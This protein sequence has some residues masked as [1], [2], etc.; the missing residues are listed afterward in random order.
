MK[1][2][3]PFHTH[4]W[5]V[6][7][8]PNGRGAP[9]ARPSRA[10]AASRRLGRSIDGVAWSVSTEWA[11]YLLFPLLVAVVLFGRPRAALAAAVGAAVVVGATVTLTMRDGAYHSGPLDAY[12][13][14][15]LEPLLRCLG[16]FVLGLVPFRLAQSPRA[17]A[18]AGH[19]LTIAAALRL[20]VSGLAARVHDLLIYPLFALLVLRLFGH[21]SEKH[22][23]ELQ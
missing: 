20:L 22:T 12:D 1:S 15:T 6:S 17:V 16:G 9:R 7:T 14:A 13:G 10:F 23:S 21:R 4:R 18:V 5:A 11:A 3:V 19:D 8:A 2:M